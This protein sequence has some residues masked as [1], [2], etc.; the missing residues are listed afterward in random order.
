MPDRGGADSPNRPSERRPSTPQ[1][2]LSAGNPFDTPTS[3]AI[4]LH[5]FERAC[6]L[7][8][9]DGITDPEDCTRTR[10]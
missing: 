4:P 2:V 3:Q 8:Q 7:D 6:R 1:S 10:P 9:I 5:L